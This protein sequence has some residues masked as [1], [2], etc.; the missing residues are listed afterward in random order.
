MEANQ[1]ACASFR[2]DPDGHVKLADLRRRYP[3]WCRGRGLLPLAQSEFAPAL[4][5]LFQSVGLRSE[6]RG[7]ATVIKGIRWNDPPTPPA[8]IILPPATAASPRLVRL[9]HMTVR[10]RVARAS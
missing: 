5:Q 4:G 6:G 3:E 2:P 1:F 8:E 9:G 7:V 10:P